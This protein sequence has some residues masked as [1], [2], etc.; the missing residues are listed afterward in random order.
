MNT[1][2]LTDWAPRSTAPLL[3]VHA[4]E[5]QCVY[6][7]AHGGSRCCM[8]VI[9]CVF[10]VNVVRQEL[11]RSYNLVVSRA[12]LLCNCRAD[13][14]CGC[15]KF[16][17]CICP[18]LKVMDT[19]PEWYKFLPLHVGGVAQCTTCLRV[20]YPR[21]KEWCA[22]VPTRGQSDSTQI[23]DD[24]GG[25]SAT[26]C[27]PPATPAIQCLHCVIIG[28]VVWDMAHRLIQKAF[29]LALPW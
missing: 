3:L 27:K 7:V 1:I 20:H 29:C 14:L 5:H 10:Y 9:G 26:Q 4:D 15:M 8:D 16:M 12:G 21:I 25:T 24:T 13:V 23:T 19:F 22:T 2:D 11:R 18:I 17:I 28:V 6:H